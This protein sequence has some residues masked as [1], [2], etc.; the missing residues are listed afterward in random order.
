LHLTHHTHIYIPLAPTLLPIITYPLTSSPK[1]SSLRPLDFDTALRAPQQY[2]K[3]KVYTDGLLE[4]GSYLF[5]EYLASA[6]LH[7]SIGFPEIVVPIVATLRRSIKTA[8]KSK[9]KGKEVGIAKTLLER[10]E[11]SAKWVEERRRGVSF[12]PGKLGEVQK[13]E[14]NVNVQDTPLGK[15][16]RVL[17]KARE[18]RRKLVEKVSFCDNLLQCT[19]ADVYDRQEMGRGKCWRTDCR[20]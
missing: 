20:F 16:V 2:I 14:N 1:P 13:W 19:P 9:G 6:P 4:E 8:S 5:A 3:T 12:A 15:Y 18:K 10:I 11:E 17:R 7:T